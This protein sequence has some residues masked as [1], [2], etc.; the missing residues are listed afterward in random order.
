MD[1]VGKI[2]TNEGVDAFN[3]ERN[4]HFDAALAEIEVLGQDDYRTYQHR[5]TRRARRLTYKV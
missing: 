1:W 2:L 4:C 5:R 3:D